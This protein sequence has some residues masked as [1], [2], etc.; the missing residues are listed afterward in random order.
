MKVSIIISAYNEQETILEVLKQIEKVTLDIEKEVIIVDD[1]STDGTRELLKALDS[2][3]YTVI[4]KDKNGG[5]GAAIKAGLTQARGDFVIFQDADLEYDPGDYPALLKPLLH[6]KADV[7]IGSRVLSSSMRLFGEGRAHW[8]SYLGCKIIAFLINFLY[9]RQGTDYYGC[10]KVFR[11]EILTSVS[12]QANGFEYDS[13][14]LCKLFKRKTRT[15]E[16]PTRYYPRNYRAGKKLSFW[17]AGFAV[18]F[19]IV[20]WRFRFG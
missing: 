1:G 18:L 11:R 14:L 9:G 13:E 2:R 5:K 8:T 16:V 6:G 10:Y 15:V 12:V 20:K 3:V 19:S 7:V 17:G 4:L